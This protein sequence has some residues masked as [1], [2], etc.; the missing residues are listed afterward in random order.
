MN[1][2]RAKLTYAQCRFHPLPVSAAWR[3]RGFCGLAAAEE[4]RRRQA[5]QAGRDHSGE[6]GGGDEKG[7]RGGNGSPGTAGRRRR[8]QSRGACRQTG[9]RF[10]SALQ[11]R[12]AARTLGARTTKRPCSK[13]LEELRRKIDERGPGHHLQRDPVCSATSDRSSK[14]S[15]TEL[16]EQLETG[17]ER[18]ARRRARPAG[19]KR[20]TGAGRAAPPPVGTASA[21]SAVPIR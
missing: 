17:N 15:K 19:I 11:A 12:R 4:Q 8:D 14:A 6:T 18:F 16:P 5:D 10:G 2:L 7:L 13:Q 9:K 3:R 21:S 1:R 20:S